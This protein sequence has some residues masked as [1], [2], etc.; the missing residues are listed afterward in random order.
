MIPSCN[1]DSNVEI[2]HIIATHTVTSTHDIDTKI[3]TFFTVT[4]DVLWNF[5]IENSIV[6]I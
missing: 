4:Q 6:S 2:N 5:F 3:T 1:A